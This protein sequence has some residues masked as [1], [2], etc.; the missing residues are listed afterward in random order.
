MD[1]Y[2]AVWVGNRVPTLGEA[3]GK[4]V[5]LS[6]IDSRLAGDYDYGAYPVYRNGK[7]VGEWAM[8]I[9]SPGGGGDEKKKTSARSY[10][11]S[12][13]K[14]S[15]WM[16]NRW[17]GVDDKGKWEWVQNSLN[18]A[19]TRRSEEREQ[20]GYN[21]WYITYTSANDI[22][23]M[24]FWRTIEYYVKYVNPRV[25]DYANGTS[26]FLGC[27]VMDA[28]DGGDASN[29]SRVIW[30]TNYRMLKNVTY[31]W[32]ADNKKCTATATGIAGGQ[33]TATVDVTSEYVKEPTCTEAGRSKLTADFS[34]T[35]VAQ[36]ASTQTKEVDAE[37]L[38]HDFAFTCADG[39]DTVVA[40]CSRASCPQAGYKVEARVHASNKAYDGSAY[41]KDSL[42][43]FEDWDHF[44]KVVQESL[45]RQYTPA[46]HSVSVSRGAPLFW[47]DG[48]VPSAEPPT[49]PGTYSVKWPVSIEVKSGSATKVSAHLEPQCTFTIE[50]KALEV[51]G[52]VAQDKTYDGSVEVE[53]DARGA[54]L[55]G[56][57]GEDKVELD[58]SAVQKQFEDPIVGENKLVLVSGVKL[59]GADASKYVLANSGEY[60]T[61]ATI[62]KRTVTITALNQV[63]YED[64][65]IKSGPAY[66]RVE[67]Q[68]GDRGLVHGERLGN[69]ALKDDR[70]ASPKTITP[71]AALILEYH[72]ENVTVCYDFSYVSGML[73]VMNGTP[74][75]T[76]P[77]VRDD[78]TYNKTEQALLNAGTNVVYSKD[79]VTACDIS[80]LTATNAG[81]YT[82]WWK[83]AESGSVTWQ[84]LT[85]TIAQKPL[86]V[87][88]NNQTKTYGQPDPAFT[89]KI[90][91]GSLESGDGLTGALTRDFSHGNYGRNVSTYTITRGSLHGSGNNY[92]ITVEPATLTIEPAKVRV[93]GITARNKVYDGTNDARIDV[94]RASLTNVLP[95][96]DLSVT[97][98][99]AFESAGAGTHFVSIFNFTL[100][101]DSAYNYVLDTTGQQARTTAE[102]KRR[103]VTVTAKRQ[104]VFEPAD[105][106]HDIDEAE[107]EGESEGRGALDGHSLAAVDLADGRW[108]DP[109]VNEVIPAHAQ[110][111]DAGGNNTTAN[112]DISYVNGA[113]TVM[114]QSIL[115]YPERRV[116]VYDGNQWP[117]IKPGNVKSGYIIQYATSQ[118]GPWSAEPPT[119]TAA[120]DYDVWWRVV[121]TEDADSEAAD[122]ETLGLVAAQELT[123]AILPCAVQLSWE[124]DTFIYD[125]ESHVP[126]ATV[127]N[128]AKADACEV[129][130]E[131][132]Q[133]N[134]GT[135]TATAM[136]LSNPNYRLPEDT[137]FEF[138]IVN[139]EEGVPFEVRVNKGAP[140]ISS[141][142][143]GSV[144]QKLVTSEEKGCAAGAEN[145]LL[146]WLESTLLASEDVTPAEKE[147]LSSMLTKLDAK[148]GTW[149]DLSLYKRVLDQT[150]QVHELPEALSFSVSVPKS[151]KKEGRTFY[152]LS[153]HEGKGELLAEGTG[154][155]LE[156]KSDR[157]STYL[158][159]YADTSSGSSPDSKDGAKNSS[160]Q[161]TA[162]SKQ[163]IARTADALPRYGLA[164]L[165]V[166]IC[167]TTLGT[168]IRRE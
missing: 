13:M 29:I 154:D 93:S 131:G 105:I 141:S 118:D 136:A 45:E 106:N 91:S 160:S 152:L 113:L 78:L 51:K 59:A 52:I 148:A 126:A 1:K 76:A 166:A 66:A 115:S 125:G 24:K 122:D 111:Q 40:T 83:P 14:Y 124:P 36:W 135:Y 104:A 165:L 97:A 71:S 88:P 28:A 153:V 5:V 16:E 47:S 41:D 44:Q 129:T 117:L 80:A 100:V 81:T 73:T 82:V 49:T 121:A 96:D 159:A 10:I 123:S 64:K 85:A 54:S 50:P 25:V 37:P 55:E 114:H 32:S 39:S 63:V 57:V 127:T 161:T 70:A 87:K 68:S 79:G 94:S 7:Y 19:E 56:V 62:N 21:P 130:V 138:S 9:A 43:M 151:L 46:E 137:T 2:P 8:Q 157:F 164:V 53:L 86:T 156:A 6:K 144:A 149:F 119:G 109:A 11:N 23:N 27:V 112:Y 143:L 15:V 128:L 139:S 72:S 99:G 92:A 22:E 34:G 90:T 33:Q 158:I 42:L 89:Y 108:A 150:T 26:S 31:T 98:D 107:I 17:A 18:D 147:A 74:D 65:D 3:R 145:G 12:T 146:V 58:L 30:E 101:G 134:V 95:G 4:V 35:A 168:W 155:V 61:T 48:S 132:V 133:T 102:I 162:S 167:T 75:Y 140:S 67:G 77:T 110:L 69:V 84:E 20:R 103:P 116:Y 142:N 163:G 120:A 60:Q 38:G